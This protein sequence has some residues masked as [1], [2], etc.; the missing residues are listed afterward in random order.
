M[1]IGEAIR[2]IRDRHGETQW[3]MALRLGIGRTH[4]TMLENDKATLSVGVL[5][6]FRRV[7]RLD[8]YLLSGMTD[9]R[10]YQR[11]GAFL[12]ECPR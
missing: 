1:T 9:E 10:L 3:R 4:L 7:Y 5:E 12:K 11:C 8:P 2:R 6:A